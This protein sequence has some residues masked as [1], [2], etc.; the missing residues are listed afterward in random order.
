MGTICESSNVT[1][2]FK[3]EFGDLPLLVLNSTVLDHTMNNHFGRFLAN[4]TELRAGTKVD[5]ECSAMGLC[6]Q[7]TGRCQC[8]EGY[9]SSDGTLTSPGERGDCSYYNPY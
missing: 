1:I 2:E 9:S 5:V 7:D 6:D 3:S 8:M 4:V